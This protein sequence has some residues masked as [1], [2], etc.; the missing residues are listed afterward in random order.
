LLALRASHF[1]PGL[2][3]RASRFVTT[4]TEI[5]GMPGPVVGVATAEGERA[6][7]ELLFREQPP[8]ERAR[9][10]DELLGQREA[11]LVSFDDLLTVTV[12]DRVL[13]VL[14]AVPHGERGRFVWP[15]VFAADGIGAADGVERGP[16]AAAAGCDV[17]LLADRLIG[18]LTAR[19][20][21]AE[22]ELAQLLGVP[23]DGRT[24][25]R[26][27]RNGFEHLADLDFLQRPL[28][29]SLGDLLTETRP[30]LRTE[31]FDEPRNRGRFEAML[32]ATY[33]GSRD[34]PGLEGRRSIESALA[35]H[36]DAGDF[37]PA[38]WL[39]FRAERPAADGPSEAADVG[40]LLLADHPGENAFEVVYMG[41]HH[42]HRGRG[43]GRAIVLEALRA[44]RDAGRESLLLAVDCGNAFARSTYAEVG[45]T[46]V[47]RR[48]V[49]V[50]F[51]GSP[52]VL[53]GADSAR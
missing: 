46:P 35:A 13:G 39:L 33:V 42:A 44:A 50:W 21:A 32:A 52:G 12:D 31:A 24:R 28:D 25:A 16:D 41:V 37:D 45:F 43:Y 38:R 23:E 7:L 34:C 20:A 26:L 27:E 1:G 36:R 49:H 19:F 17:E 3:L 4:R 53:G 14:L 18:G 30:G 2:A 47:V 10:I 29:D 6:A 11:G 5:E 8:R 15:P 48:C 9:C 40:V 22:V 51:G